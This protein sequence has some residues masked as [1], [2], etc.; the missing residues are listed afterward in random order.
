MKCKLRTW[1]L[2]DAKDLAAALNNKH[3]LKISETKI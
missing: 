3:I 1:R 2:S